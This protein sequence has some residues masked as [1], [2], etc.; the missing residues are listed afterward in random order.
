M[1]D[2][3]VGLTTL[4]WLML[5]TVTLSAQDPQSGHG[6]PEPRNAE[7]QMAGVHWAK[8]Q[9]PPSG[10]ARRLPTSAGMA[11]PSCPRP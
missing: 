2:R 7:P 1:I 4:A 9:A 3:R 10:G 5:F 11:V 8:G 6:K